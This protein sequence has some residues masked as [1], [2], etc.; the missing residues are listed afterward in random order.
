M[1]VTRRASYLI[2]IFCGP[3]T[4]VG[5]RPGGEAG[6]KKEETS[7]EG[8][9]G[10]GH[11]AR[12]RAAR[13]ATRSGPPA[14]PP[15]TAA[16]TPPAPT[17]GPPPLSV[18]PGRGRPAPRCLLRLPRLARLPPRRSIWF[19]PSSSSSSS[20]SAPP[21]M[22]SPC[23]SPLHV[24]PPGKSGRGGPEVCGMRAG[25]GTGESGAG[26]PRATAPG[27]GVSRVCGA[28]MKERSPPARPPPRFHTTPPRHSAS[29]PPSLLPPGIG[30]IQGSA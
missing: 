13:A 14:S 30:G 21:S 17:P 4:T 9:G 2:V 16:P 10:D 23:L 7:P 8:I 26:G 15:A 6:K 25:L 12:G 28:E 27:P 19:L 24:V 5:K 1:R 22:L 18:P 29:P 20:S 11:G 3:G